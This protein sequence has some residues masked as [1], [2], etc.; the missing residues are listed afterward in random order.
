MKKVR[1]SDNF[2][3][4]FLDMDICKDILYLIVTF[5]NLLDDVKK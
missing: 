5:W 2:K 1:H 4:D 3:K